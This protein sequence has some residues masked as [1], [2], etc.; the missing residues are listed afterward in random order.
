LIAIAAGN[1]RALK[2]LYLG[3]QGAAR[4]STYRHSA[5]VSGIAGPSRDATILI[6]IE[7]EM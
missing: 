7:T 4:A 2:E 1:C 3:Y 6:A 5:A